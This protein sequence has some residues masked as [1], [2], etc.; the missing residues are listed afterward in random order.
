ML[1]AVGR[2]VRAQHLHV[3]IR[4]VRQL[5]EG[6]EP[7]ALAD[8]I[9]VEYV[10]TLAVEHDPPMVLDRLALP[11]IPVGA[12]F[13]RWQVPRKQRLL[14]VRDG[15]QDG[16]KGGQVGPALVGLDEGQAI[17]G[18]SALR[19]RRVRHG[20]HGDGPP[21]VLVVRV[22]IDL[23]EVRARDL[24]HPVLLPRVQA[25]RDHVG[26]AF[27]IVLHCKDES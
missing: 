27:V 16:D 3:A 7:L 21:V 15:V 2:D 6:H 26:V 9:R 18:P 5:E 25:D 1:H 8:E 14:G 13:L 11:P 4:A 20:G 24:G 12:V 17:I 10:V 22:V 23:P 19:G